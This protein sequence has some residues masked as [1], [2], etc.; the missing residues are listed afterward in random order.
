MEPE[1]N[2]RLERRTQCILHEKMLRD[3]SQQIKDIHRA[4]YGNGDPQKGLMFQSELNS[5][6]RQNCE[7]T[8]RVLLNVVLGGAVVGAVYFI[9]MLNQHGFIK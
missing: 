5:R 6:W 2:E 4:I 7:M 8:G 9:I 1:L 3:M